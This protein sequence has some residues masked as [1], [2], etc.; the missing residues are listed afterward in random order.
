[1]Y[2]NQR[3]T[4]YGI[5]SYAKIYNYTKAQKHYTYTL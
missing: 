5:Y 1:M 4:H 3:Y 2:N